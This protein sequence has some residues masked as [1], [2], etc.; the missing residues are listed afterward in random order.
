ML[1]GSRKANALRNLIYAWMSQGFT[2]IMNMV[3]R[4]IFV[5]VL[6]KD[7]VGISGLFSNII[8]I[9]SVAELGIGSAIVY[10]LYEPLARGE[11]KKVKALMQFY[12]RVYISIG[13]FILIAGIALTPYLSLFIK[14]MPDI[15]QL[16]FIYILF[17]CNAAS[18]YFFSYK[19]TLISAD[20]K[21]YILKRIRIK[22][23]FLM[24]L[25][26]ITILLLTRDY[27]P[28]LLV[29]VLATIEMNFA[30]SLAADKA[31]PYLKDKDRVILGKEQFRQIVKNTKALICHKIGTVIVFS[32][33]NLIISKFTGLG[34]VADYSNYILIQET[35]NGILT[36]LFS[37]LAPS[38]GN[39]VAVED[40]RKSLEV[41]WR[42]MFLNA[43]LYGGSALCFFCLGQDF[44]RTF[45]GEDYVI[46]TEILLVIIVNF[47]LTGIRKSV[48][49]FKDAYGLFFQNRYTPLIESGINLLV[50][51]W[52]VQI[53]GV[54]GVL[55]GTTVSSLL[56]PVWSEPYVLFR[57]GF[58]SPVVEYWKQYI[59]YLLLILGTG[60][61]VWI[62]CGRIRYVPVISFLLKGFCC[63]IVINSLFFII[64]RNDKNMKY[65]LGI[66]RTIRK[67]RG[68]RI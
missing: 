62:L 46:S 53:Y 63:V 50:S 55:L 48:I 5:H 8:T 33:D 16:A 36:Q 27:I 44:V 66:I 14:E 34:N 32:T 7:Y 38:V 59:K 65:Y 20:Q 43:W 29:Q 64:L 51:V 39:M 24:Y 35:L 10:G 3:V 40:A 56:A 54:I 21:D 45:F 1:Q 18:S 52:L 26:Q 9:L 19:G 25:V 57:Y 13:C 11:N 28:Y 22:V 68:G 67:G 2:V 4:V 31:Y 60:S 6:S 41:F 47:Y 61:I 42:I 37:A 49:T 17:V 12:Q 15:P 23:L 30:F 58:R